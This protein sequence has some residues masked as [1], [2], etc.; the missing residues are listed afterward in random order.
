MDNFYIYYVDSVY[1]RQQKETVNNIDAE[2]GMPIMHIF[3]FALDGTFLGKWLSVEEVS[4][5]YGVPVIDIYLCVYGITLTAAGFIFT[6]EDESIQ[7]LT[8]MT[9]EYKVNKIKPFL[10]EAYD[11]RT[12]SFHLFA[13]VKQA[14]EASGISV[15]ELS[16]HRYYNDIYRGW[17]LYIP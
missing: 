16:V 2:C 6:F 7:V 12:H 9:V 14:S 10:I 17:T 8:K 1:K 3:Q 4:K 11:F 5:K 15:E 13:T